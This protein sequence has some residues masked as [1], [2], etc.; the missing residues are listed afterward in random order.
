MQQIQRKDNKVQSLEGEL[1]QTRGE[2]LRSRE[3]LQK[4]RDDLYRMEE[5]KKRLAEE[6]DGFRH[7]LEQTKSSAQVTSAALADEVNHDC[8]NGDTLHSAVK[9]QCNVIQYN[10]M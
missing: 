10:V 3:S 7:Q 4:Y 9:I 8:I 1:E 2:S 6:K 5:E